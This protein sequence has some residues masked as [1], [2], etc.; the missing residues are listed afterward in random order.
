MQDFANTVVLICAAIASLGLGLGLALAVCKAGFA[1]LGA[2]SRTARPA[3][4][5]AKAR[6][7]EI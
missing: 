7:V 2:Q 4:L 1:L 3:P 6:I 5:P